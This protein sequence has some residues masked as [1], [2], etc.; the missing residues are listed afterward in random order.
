MGEAARMLGLLV[1]R[2]Q[3]TKHDG[4]GGRS[5]KGARSGLWALLGHAASAHIWS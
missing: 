1:R 2:P 3:D 4:R 5:E